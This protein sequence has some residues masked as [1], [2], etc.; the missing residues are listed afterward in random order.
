MLADFQAVTDRFL[1]VLHQQQ[2]ANPLQVSVLEHGSKSLPCCCASL[3]IGVTQFCSALM[4]YIFVEKVRCQYASMISRSVIS[5][6][7][8]TPAGNL[9]YAVATNSNV[10]KL[11]EGKCP[12]Y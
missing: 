10:G 12:H 2:E 4:Y 11:S 8:L 1:R 5:G 7:S 3:L 9:L 6:H